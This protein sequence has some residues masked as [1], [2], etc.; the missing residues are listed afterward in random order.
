MSRLPLLLGISASVTKPE[1]IF[2]GG[3]ILVVQPERREVVLLLR[4]VTI[5]ISGIAIP[6]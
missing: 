4:G 6:N 2:Y 3:D 5:Q 1:P